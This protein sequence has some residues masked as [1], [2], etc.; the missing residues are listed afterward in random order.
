MSWVLHWIYWLADWLYVQWYDSTC[1]IW[2]TYINPEESLFQ[3]ES[4]YIIMRV[5]HRQGR[6]GLELL[7]ETPVG[8][9]EVHKM[10]FLY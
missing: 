9:G 5:H 8:R 3:T 10:S 6:E 4:K 1:Y 7:F 2:Y